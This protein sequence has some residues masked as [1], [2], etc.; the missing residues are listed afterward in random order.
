MIHL[1]A[2]TPD[3]WRSGLRVRE[4][5]REYVAD[6]AGLLARAYAYRDSRSRAFLICHDDTPIGMALFYDMDEM[7]AY[8]FSQFFID[9]R[10]QQH[11]YG[12]EAARL[13]LDLMRADGRYNRVVLC[14]VDGDT[15]AERLYTKLGFTHTGNADEDEIV[16]ERRL[17]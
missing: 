11:G 5:Q 14:Y 10:Y 8:N 13:V 4:E 12:T 16:M 3:N 1:E 17:R 7:Q 6:S 9:Q 15:A 2:I